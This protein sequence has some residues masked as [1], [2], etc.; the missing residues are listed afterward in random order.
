MQKR[1]ANI[2]TK[3]HQIL[4]SKGPN[5]SLFFYCCQPSPSYFQ[6]NGGAPVFYTPSKQGL[7]ETNGQERLYLIEDF[8]NKSK[9]EIIAWLEKYLEL[10]TYEFLFLSS[11]IAAWRPKGKPD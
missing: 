7:G 8:D 4:S 5:P 3:G 11:G 10:N 6:E 9:T 1:S 2:E